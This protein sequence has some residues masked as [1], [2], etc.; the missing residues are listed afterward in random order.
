MIYNK[1][2]N[3]PF[4]DTIIRGVD[5]IVDG[6]Y[7]RNDSK[8]AESLLTTQYFDEYRTAFLKLPRQTG[9]TTY[10]KKL[11]LHFAQ[12]GGHNPVI[13]TNNFSQK[14]INYESGLE[15]KTVQELKKRQ[16]LVGRSAYYDIFLCDEVKPQEAKEVLAHLCQ[17]THNFSSKVNFVLGLYT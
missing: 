4:D 8:Y 13:V 14:R 1:Q 5:K 11:Y 7:F 9:K 2:E 10:L 15:T 17:Y 12:K 6:L 16:T 3:A